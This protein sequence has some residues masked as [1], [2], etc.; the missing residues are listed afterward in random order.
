M[1]SA[2]PSKESCAEH[3]GKSLLDMGTALIFAYLAAKMR[4]VKSSA[5]LYA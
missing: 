4:S 5:A 3:Q 2:E 1:K